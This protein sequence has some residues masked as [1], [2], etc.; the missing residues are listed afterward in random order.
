ML[1]SPVRISASKDCSAL[2]VQMPF[3]ICFL[4]EPSNEES[5]LAI[6]APIPRSGSI[7]VASVIR[8][9]TCID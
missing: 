6:A 5:N 8:S 3:R 7:R 4:P 9:S 2:N 1:M